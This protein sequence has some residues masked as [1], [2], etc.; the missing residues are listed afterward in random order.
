[1]VRVTWHEKEI[2]ITLYPIRILDTGKTILDIVVS[3]MFFDPK[4][5]LIVLCQFGWGPIITD[6][7]SPIML[8]EKIPMYMFFL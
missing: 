7:G 8:V 1:M 2:K 6:H 3:I 4:L 5:V